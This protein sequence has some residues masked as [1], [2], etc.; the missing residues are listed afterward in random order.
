VD[1]LRHHTRYSPPGNRPAHWSLAGSAVIVVG[2]WLGAEPI[3][4]EI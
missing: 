1:W 2:T 3:F 4:N